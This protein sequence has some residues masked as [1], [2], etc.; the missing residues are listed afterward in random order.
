MKYQKSWL[1][2]AALVMSLGLGGCGHAATEGSARSEGEAPVQ[3][4]EADQHGVKTVTL[5]EQAAQRLGL[6]DATVRPVAA[7]SSLTGRPQLVMPYAA[8]VYDQGGQTWAY[9]ISQPLTYV[10]TAVTVDHIDGDA[11]YL[12]SGPDSGSAVVTT[13]SEELLG[14]EYEISGE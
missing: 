2:A 10:R 12:S 14:A 3:L 9:L 6:A 13:G 11:A 5:S 7:Q 4:S 8:L 1:A